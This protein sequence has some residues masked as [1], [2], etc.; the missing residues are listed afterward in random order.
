M[1]T[2]ATRN[3][4]SDDYRRGLRRISEALAT[5]ST[6]GPSPPAITTTAMLPALSM[7]S[8]IALLRRWFDAQPR[9]GDYISFM[10]GSGKSKAIA[11]DGEMF[12]PREGTEDE[13]I[14]ETGRVI[15]GTRHQP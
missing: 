12:L 10:L 5:R 6:A 4:V 9:K 3:R 7:T 13:W 8:T 1:L 2:D 11:M 15:K 14:S